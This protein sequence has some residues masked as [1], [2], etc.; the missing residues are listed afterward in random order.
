MVIAHYGL[1]QKS[2]QISFEIINR[3]CKRH[4]RYNQ[5]QCNTR[6]LQIF[7]NQRNCILFVH[8]DTYFKLFIT[9]N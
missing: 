2:R 4:S 1:Y 3:I 8:H 5:V 9:Y 7:T 6:V